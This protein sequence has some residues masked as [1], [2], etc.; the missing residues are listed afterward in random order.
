M[1]CGCKAPL[2]ILHLENPPS[3][4]TIADLPTILRESSNEYKVPPVPDG[5]VDDGVGLEVFVKVTTP[6]FTNNNFKCDC[7]VV[8]IPETPPDIPVKFAP[9]PTKLVAVTTPAFPNLILFPTSNA[10]KVDMPAVVLKFTP[11]RFKPA[12][13]PFERNTF[14]SF[15]CAVI[16]VIPET[17]L[18]LITVIYLPPFFIYYTTTRVD[19]VAISIVAP[20]ATVVG[21]IS[22]AFL[23]V[24]IETEV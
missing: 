4:K 24:P 2:V 22:K 20:T 9:D 14:I 5:N 12:S 3:L 6:A 21:P 17:L 18:G 23:P 16:L 11:L 19:P 7:P 1:P 15:A 8:S 13:V 10:A